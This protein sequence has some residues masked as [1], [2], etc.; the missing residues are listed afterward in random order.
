MFRVLKL[1]GWTV[2]NKELLYIGGFLSRAVYEFELSAMQKLL[3]TSD[4]KSTAIDPQVL[5]RIT[6]RVIHALKFFRFYTSTPSSDV[7]SLMESAFFN[8]SI[9]VKRFPIVSNRG[10]CDVADVRL[11]DPTFSFLKELPTLPDAVATGAPLMI[12]ALQNRDM[13][14][15]INFQDVLRELQSRPL[16]QDEF[17]S[18]L[19][20]WSNLFQ[21]G[22]R[23]RLLPIRT[24]LINS[25]IL[26][27]NNDKGVQKVIPLSSIKSFINPRSPCINIPSDS[28]LPDYL[29]P[30]SVSKQFKVETLLNSF[31][32]TE[33]T[34]DQWL[35]YICEEKDLSVEYDLNVS[36]PWAERVIGLIVRVWPN[37][38]A[39]SKSE[40]IQLLRLRTCIP[41]SGGMVL[42]QNAY[43][44]NVN[45]FGDLPVVTFPSNLVIKGP[46][47]KFLQDLGIRKHVELQVV[48]NRYVFHHLFCLGLLTFVISMIKTNE[49]T[50]ADLTK[51]LVSVRA[52]LTSEELQRLK[53]TSAFPKESQGNPDEAAKRMRF[54]ANQLYEPLDVFRTMKLPII[55]WGQQMKWKSSS[56]EGTRRLL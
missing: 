1:A 19:N 41:T 16:A 27:Y 11:P 15:P 37:V 8:C 24:Q 31:P 53:A 39:A 38:P 6:N 48:F 43:F 10:V 42:P 25:V 52:S 18:C 56:E 9:N 49:W 32:W 22:N 20:W 17:V 30:L 54:T 26:A 35:R 7:S 44:P 5:E 29:L 36:P 40:I 12:A 14:K 33:L 3:M 34:I 4:P 28:P 50:I 46:M 2:W 45:I 55:D 23:E 47:E 21:D 13:I 51:Y